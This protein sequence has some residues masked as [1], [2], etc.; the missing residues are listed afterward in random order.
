MSHQSGFVQLT[1]WI[2]DP[3]PYAIDEVFD[4]YRL[5]AESTG[6]AIGMSGRNLNVILTG[7][8]A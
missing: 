2:V 8:S 3:Y 6:K 5:L 7:D 1:L 4:V